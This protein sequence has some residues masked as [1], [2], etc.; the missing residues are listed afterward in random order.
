VR[1]LPI[2]LLHV[3]ATVARLAGPGGVRAVVAESVL[4]KQGDD[5]STR[6]PSVPASSAPGEE[7]SG[8]P[9]L[10]QRL[11][12]P[13]GAGGA[14]PANPGCERR[15]RES[16]F[17]SLAV[18]L[19][20]A[21]SDAAGGMNVDVTRRRP[22]KCDVSPTGAGGRVTHPD[23]EFATHTVSTRSV[24]CNAARSITSGAVAWPA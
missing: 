2:P 19:S 13:H 20:R 17:A 3:V 9:E 22:E 11:S 15:P 5:L 6:G 14:P 7:A 1:D 21:V 10:L 23:V 24:I 18:A 12:G 4:V 8:I 16:P